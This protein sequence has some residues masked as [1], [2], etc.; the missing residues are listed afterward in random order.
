VNSLR[1]CHIT[2]VHQVFDGR[3]FHK[4]CSSLARHGHEVFLV[5]RHTTD[6]TVNGVYIRAIAEHSASGLGRLKN[7]LNAW[8]SARALNADI[9]HFHDPEF[10]MPAVLLKLFSRGKVVYDAHEDPATHMMSKNWIPPV[11]RKILSVMLGIVERVCQYFFD[12]VITVLDSHQVRFTTQSVTL[13]NYSVP[14]ENLA[15][16]PKPHNRPAVI[17]AGVVREKRAILETLEAVAW[18]KK[19]VPDILFYLVGGAV[20]ASFEDQIRAKVSELGLDENV[21]IVGRIPFTDVPQWINK[22]DFGLSL[23]KPD[24]Y[25]KDALQTKIFEY[26][27]LE[28]PVVVSDFPIL[29]KLVDEARCGIAVD[30]L[31]IRAIAGAMVQLLTEPETCRQMGQNGRKA[32]MEKYNWQVEEKKLFAL[33]QRLSEAEE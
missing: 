24:A 29:K 31:D 7:T 33:Y 6:E 27:I 28:R 21:E 23:T 14:D 9:Y 20:P 11:P 22:A 8:Q 16:R 1:V 17:Y 10:L 12:A 4:E 18:A 5:A 26:L 13:H 2:T 15:P 32:V 3:I 25:H 19:Q 30:P